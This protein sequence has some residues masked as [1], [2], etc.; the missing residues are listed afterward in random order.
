MPTTHGLAAGVGWTTGLSHD[1]FATS[2]VCILSTV[3]SNRPPLR[4]HVART[5]ALVLVIIR[6]LLSVV[7]VHASAPTAS[8]RRRLSA[9]RFS[10]RGW[11]PAEKA[12]WVGQSRR[13]V[14]RREGKTRKR[15]TEVCGCLSSGLLGCA[16]L[17]ELP[18]MQAGR[19][20]EERWKASTRCACRP[21][22]AQLHTPQPQHRLLL[23]VS[24]SFCPCA[25]AHDEISSCR[26]QGLI[27]VSGSIDIRGP[28]CSACAPHSLRCMP[29]IPLRLSRPAATSWVR[30]LC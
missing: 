8:V 17:C 29:P 28:A 7:V 14:W 3:H 9:D 22:P 12:R 19:L 10:P 5:V 6:M 23:V 26:A 24:R 30:I 11:S 13:S 15:C 16:W 25:C 27:R 1:S 18:L 2:S 21:C 4:R 20:A